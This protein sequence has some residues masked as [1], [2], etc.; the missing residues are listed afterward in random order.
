MQAQD[1]EAKAA[2][3][4]AAQEAE[5]AAEV[6]NASAGRTGARVSIRT[7]KRAKVVDYHAAAKA[8]VDANHKDM[9]ATI[10]QLAQRAVKAGVPLAGVE[11]ETVEKVV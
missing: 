7:E 8:L 2:A 5:K 4:K 11:V 3:L 10:D 9:L 1:E 6:K